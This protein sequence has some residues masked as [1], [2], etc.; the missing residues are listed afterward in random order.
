MIGNLKRTMV[1]LIVL[2][3][4]GIV[5]VGTNLIRSD[6]QETEQNMQSL[7]YRMDENDTTFIVRFVV[8]LG[9]VEGWILPE[10][11]HEGDLA[12]SRTLYEVGSD[13]FCVQ[14]SGQGSREIRCV[15]FANVSEI[16]FTRID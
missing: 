5:T 2:G 10:F 6:A 12:G 16:S 15:P 8:P 7:L 13:Y 14:E 11:D 9:D 4:L 3:L 1:I